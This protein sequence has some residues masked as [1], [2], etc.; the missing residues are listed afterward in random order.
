MKIEAVKLALPSKIVTN[1]DIIDLIKQHSNSFHGELETILKEIRYYLKYSG[2]NTRYWLNEGETPIQ[3]LCQATEDALKAANINKED[4]DVLVYV[5]IGR[6]FLE[7]GGAYHA[8]N[9][10]NMHHV[11]CYDVIDACMSWTRAMQQLQALFDASVFRRALVVNAEFNMIENGA[12]YPGV[13]NLHDSRSVEWTF[14]AFT[15]GE[16]ASATIISAD[17]PDNLWT[18]NF[19]SRADLS[20]LCNIPIARYEGY[21]VASEKIGKNGVGHFTSFGSDLV[22]FGRPHILSVMQK[23]LNNIEISNIKGIFTHASSQRDWANF[24]SELDLDHL[25]HH[26]YPQTGNL[27]SASIPGAIAIAMETGKVKQNDE[28]IGW[29][30]S[31]GMSFCAYHFRL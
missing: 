1:D 5:G 14:P 4:I 21:C 17:D 18:F 11:Q 12:I 9:A 28:V 7:P 20:D 8:A 22:K 27:V 26:I 23:T 24:A 29:V 19:E 15:L 16:G 25:V 13:F 3:L 6:G 31:A 30:G 10:L 2:S